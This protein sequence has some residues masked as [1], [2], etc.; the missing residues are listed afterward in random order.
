[1]SLKYDP[2]FFKAFE[3]MLGVMAAFPKPA[4]HDVE[5][6]RKTLETGLAALVDNMPFPAPDVEQGEHT[7]TTASGAS[8]K[9]LSFV[10]KGASTSAGP[11]ILHCHGGG[12]ILGTAESNAK[13]CAF[14]VQQTG[15]PIFSV[16]YRLAPE[17][18]GTTLVEDCYAGLEWLSK[19]A[20]QFNVDPARIA[21]MGESAGGGLAAG[22]ALMARDKKLSPPLA[23]QIL[24]YPMLDDRNLTTN[25][26][27]L[28]F[29]FWNYEDNITGWTALLGADKAGKPDAD[30]SHYCAPAR[31]KSLAGL[32]PTYIDLGGL[33]IFRDEDLEYASRLAK[34]DIE[35]ELHLYPG[36]PHAFELFGPET[37]VVKSVFA[38]RFKAM[39]TF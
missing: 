38:N 23:K 30:V 34:E 36:L 11:A 31:A 2:E 9:V 15:V 26:A 28:P 32:P 19:N 3:P 39:Q 6:R 29:A 37:S 8:I 4:V 35:V 12:M 13:P 17:V 18:Q 7:I 24:I 25:D 14:Q 27:L 20:A 22:V 16:D 33:D 1:M 10:K 5:G 21:V